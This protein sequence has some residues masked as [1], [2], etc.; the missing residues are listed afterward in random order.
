MKYE[1]KEIGASKRKIEVELTAE[2]FDNFYA[3]TLKNFT[4]EAELPGFR[5]GKA[6][7]QMVEEKI[8]PDALLSEAGEIAIRDSWLKILKET[9]MDAIA[10]PQ[11]EIV[12]I[13]KNNPFVFT[14]EVESLPKVELPNIR[15]IGAKVCE[16]QEKV[17]V[18]EKDIEDTIKWLQQSRAIMIE[19]D[20]GIENGDMAEI[21]F[22][23]LS[24]IEG[25]PKGP[26]HDNFILG[27]G[28]YI[29]GMEQALLGMKK[30]EV[31]KIAGE[32]QMGGEKGKKEKVEISLLVHG[33]KK[34]EMPEITDDWA[35]SLGNFENLAGLKAD[36]KKGITEEKEIANREK[37][38]AEVLEKINEKT[39]VEIP[40][41]LISREETALFENL[42]SRVQAEMNM[43][44][45]AYLEQIKKTEQELKN[46]F[47]KVA[48]QR[49]KTFLVLNQ[50]EKDEK[51]E[52][53][54]AEVS[55]KVEQII[56]QYPDPEKAR[57]EIEASDARAYF[58]DEIK[59]EKIFKLLGC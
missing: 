34:V 48:E 18:T 13:A 17:E 25:L 54:E 37:K 49:V 41:S 27:K 58:T 15:E 5:K 40:V 3:E 6:P 10:A 35:K 36:I 30:E 43:P 57:K 42:K 33:V 51:I 4:S 14:M 2:E 44:L 59:R 29:N 20:G 7:T 56:K 21:H 31:K 53:T 38:R 46:D 50:I 52:A 24:E 32:V 19:K 1:I 8:N 23:F 39:K 22:E 45:A 28:Y 16:K 11:V 47:K 12:K 9:K 55:E 26:Q